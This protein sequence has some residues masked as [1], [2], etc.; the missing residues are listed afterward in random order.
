[1]KPNYIVVIFFALTISSCAS[2]L[3]KPPSEKELSWKERQNSTEYQ[4]EKAIFNERLGNRKLCFEI[5]LD[6]YLKD[7]APIPSKQCLYPHSKFTISKTSAGNILGQNFKQLK[8]LGS[9]DNGFLLYSPLNSS[10]RVIYLYKTIEENLVDGA[11]LDQK[12]EWKL[13][14]YVGVYSYSTLAGKSTVY[15]FKKVPSEYFSKLNEGLK[16]YNPVADYHIENEL[17]DQIWPIDTNEKANWMHEQQDLLMVLA[18][19]QAFFLS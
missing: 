17:W 7:Y 11:F 16:L 10:N 4:K 14:E 8:V 6:E 1:M 13:Y 2:I 5:G 12:Q 3:H 18:N 9:T 19:I 15:A